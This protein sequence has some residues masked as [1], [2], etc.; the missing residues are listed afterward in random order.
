MD[1]EVDEFKLK[2][3]DHSR[4]QFKKKRRQQTKEKAENVVLPKGKVYEE[5]FSLLSQVSEGVI[6]NAAMIHAARKRRELARSSGGGVGGAAYISLNQQPS[7]ASQGD[8]Q[9]GNDDDDNSDEEPTK[10][11]QFGVKQ[12][13]TK[14]MQVLSA[15]DNAESGSDEDRFEKQQI[16]KGTYSFPVAIPSE[17]QFSSMP[18][19]DPVQM[20]PLPD[21]VV[22]RGQAESKIVLTPISFESLQSQLRSQ[23][24]QLQEQRS[25]NSDTVT[26]LRDDLVEAQSEIEEAEALSL[27][28]S[29]RYQFYQETRGYVKDLLLCL[30]EKVSVMCL[31]K[32]PCSCDNV[33]SPLCNPLRN[34][35]VKRAHLCS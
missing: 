18:Y 30:T 33:S 1:D 16:N 4:Q 11:R 28:L 29:M 15:M 9:I 3:P 26:K 34:Y 20:P 5:D 14:Q 35:G 27:T 8:E 25:S 6:P 31:S 13:A 32:T 21:N 22:G 12:D 2:K 24:T 10:V 19:E 23:L 17:S 7:D